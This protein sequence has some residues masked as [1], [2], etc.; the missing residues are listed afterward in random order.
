MMSVPLRQMA[1]QAFADVNL[2]FPGHEA[3]KAYR[4]ELDLDTAIAA[5]RYTVGDTTFTREVFSSAPDQVIVVRL[6]AGKGGQ[7][8]FTATFA[9]PHAGARAR[10]LAADTLAVAGGVANGVLTFEAQLRVVAEGGTTAVTDDGITV[11]GADAV[12]LVLAAGTSFKHYDDVS[13]DPAARCSATL[14]AV[15][16]KDYASLRAAHVADHRRLFRRVSL[17]LPATDAAAQPTD[18][19]IAG[20][21]AQADP[22]L[23]AMYFQYGRYLLIASSREGGQP[24]LP[25]R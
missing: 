19:R 14:K 11:Q 3:A 5:V 18:R 23:G 20:F 24:T 22:Q 16:G 15:A 13:A 8:T 4:R 1:Y 17:D 6:A 21:T 12:T 10:R 7:V 9:S 25:P 2:S